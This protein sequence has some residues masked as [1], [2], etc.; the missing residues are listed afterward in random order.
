MIGLLTP[1]VGMVLYAMSSVA[2][3]SI[4]ALTKELWPFMISILVVLIAITYY[5]P[6]VTALPKLFFR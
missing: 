3:V 6:L 4:T 5:P 1:P 2:K